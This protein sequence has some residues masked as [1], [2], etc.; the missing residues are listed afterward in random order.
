MTERQIVHLFSARI[1]FGL[2]S[3]LHLKIRSMKR[4]NSHVLILFIGFSSATFAQSKPFKP[5]KGM[6]QIIP[7]YSSLE[8]E[9]GQKIYY[10]ASVHGSVGIQVNVWSNNDGILKLSG[11]HFAYNDRKKAKQPGGDAAT[12]TY[13]FEAMQA[14]KSIVMI[15]KSFRGELKEEF[16]V[17]IIVREKG[18]V[19]VEK[20]SSKVPDADQ[21]TVKLIPLKDKEVIKLGQKIIYTANVHGSVGK[22]VKVFAEDNGVLQLIDTKF[23]YNKKQVEGMSGGDAATNSFIFEGT[24]VGEATITIQEI[25]R[26][27]VKNE[28]TIVVH[29]IDKK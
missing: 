26:G 28:Y 2:I 9:V 12:K 3:V 20:V 8:V 1:R 27:E 14:G 29:V 21:D 15:E 10:S 25:F 5:E 24:K 7:L 4:F 22:G 23:E 16:K 11:T 6:K 18:E 19:K 13:V 17:E